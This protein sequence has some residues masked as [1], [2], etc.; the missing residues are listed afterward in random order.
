MTKR[1]S[2]NEPLRIV[3]FLIPEND[4]DG[5][6]LKREVYKQIQREIEELFGGWSIVGHE[7]MEGGWKN[8]DTGEHF[9]GRSWRYRVDIEAYRFEELDEYLAEIAARLGEEA[10]HRERLPQSE[11]KSIPA[12]RKKD[13]K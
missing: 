13:K 1:E 4:N 11:A 8:R 2:N 3:E 5:N 6:P 7:P 9:Q 10:I 12:K